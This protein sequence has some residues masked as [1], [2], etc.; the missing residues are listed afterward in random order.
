MADTPASGSRSGGY[1]KGRQRR[2]EILRTALE[3]LAEVGYRKT[4]LRA[5]ARELGLQPAHVLHY[6]SSREDLLLQ[7]FQRWGD[8]ASREEIPEGTPFLERWIRQVEHNTTVPGLVHLYTAFAAEAADPGHPAHDY[9]AGRF[10][11]LRELIA[12]EV[13]AG[14][15]SGVLRDDLVPDDVAVSLI[16]LSDGLQ[17]QWLVDP[18]IDMPSRMRDAVEVLRVRRGAPAR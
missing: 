16:S 11:R 8:P 13:Q 9:F 5:I 14:I 2:E 12:A 18:E 1:A 17:L 4:S 6:F 7:V 3:V 15:E 10:L